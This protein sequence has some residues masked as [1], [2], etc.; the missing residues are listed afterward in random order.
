MLQTATEKSND[1]ETIQEI[2][3]DIVE[4]F[5]NLE[6][7]RLLSY[8][9]DDIILM[10]QGMPLVQG[11]TKVREMFAA[12]KKKGVKIKLSYDI[13]EIELENKL[14]FVRG[15]VYRTIYATENA[16]AQKDTHRFVCLFKKLDT[17]WLRTHVM[18]NSAS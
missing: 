11:K 12:F 7:E 14:A 5:N 6:L 9:S 3:N 17:G 16:A 2:L 10:D 8:H 4:S 13:H 1:R 18:A 15:T